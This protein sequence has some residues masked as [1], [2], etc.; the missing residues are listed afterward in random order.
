MLPRLARSARSR[1]DLPDVEKHVSEVL[2]GHFFEQPPCGHDVLAEEPRQVVSPGS[3][4]NQLDASDVRKRFR[5]GRT[6]WI[7]LHRDGLVEKQVI[8]EISACPVAH[9]RAEV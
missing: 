2:T 4:D 9:A 6:A 5:F 8:V 1:S 7:A 3:R